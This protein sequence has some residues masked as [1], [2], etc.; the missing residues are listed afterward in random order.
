[1]DRISR[2]SQVVERVKFDD[3]QIPSLLFA[4]DLILLASSNSDLQLSLARFVAECE[5][6]GMRIGTS[7]S[8]AM[9]LSQ[10]R[11]D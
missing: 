5:A 10:K 3:L 6:V 11:V 8:K 1:M 7:K 9:V 4:D 2:S